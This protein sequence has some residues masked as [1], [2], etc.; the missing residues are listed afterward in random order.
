MRIMNQNEC[1]RAVRMLKKTADSIEKTIEEYRE[2]QKIRLPALEARKKRIDRTI[3]TLQDEI[4]WIELIYEDI[5]KECFG[6]EE[7]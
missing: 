5:K 7:R 6:F 3:Q 1:E 2:L 4:R